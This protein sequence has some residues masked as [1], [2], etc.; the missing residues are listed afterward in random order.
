[1]QG[2]ADSPLPLQDADPVKS[3]LAIGT[4]YVALDDRWWKGDDAMAVSCEFH[5]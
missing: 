4:W 5:R 3:V 2:R 1:M